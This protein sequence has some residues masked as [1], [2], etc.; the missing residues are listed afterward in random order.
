MAI[1]AKTK[2]FRDKTEVTYEKAK[3]QT[4]ERV[5]VNADHDAKEV[6]TAIEIHL[7]ASK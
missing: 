5:V 1:N 3:I 6:M 4:G 7:A 2:I